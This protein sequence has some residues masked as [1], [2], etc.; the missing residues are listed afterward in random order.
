MPEA[1]LPVRKHHHHQHRYHPLEE[2]ISSPNGTV[3]TVFDYNATDLNETIEANGE[4]CNRF[5]KN[6]NITWINIDGLRQEEVQRLCKHYDVHEL[7]VEDIMSRNERPKMDEIENVIF[8]VLPMMYFNQS[9]G[10]VEMEQVSL[11]LGNDFVLSFQEEA[12][13]DVL[14]TV[15][16]HLRVENSKIRQR[17]SDYLLY[18]ILDVIVDSYFGVLEQIGDRLDTLEDTLLRRQ[19]ASLLNRISGLR[20]DVALLRRAI[21]PV[22]ELV[23][24]FVRSDSKLLEERNEKYFRDVLDHTIQATD[25]MENHR[26][27]VMNLQDL[28]MNQI[29]L[30][31][32]EVMKVFTMVATLLAPAT[33]IGGI[34]G[35]NFD[36]IPMRHQ[37]A[38]FWLAVG[39]ML[40]IP[41]LM[42]VWFKRRGWF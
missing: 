2:V 7:V 42:L 17:K 33:V 12:E 41:M 8:C 4:A 10:D 29:N 20:R 11:V 1:N 15:R 21:L 22:R 35:M 32:N 25:F 34:F 39:A 19:N 14:D 38:G 5:H 18:S 28:Y 6:G 36:V 37:G 30:K 16:R 27:M 31:M 24:H 26:E 23:A 9:T 13:R 40:I 3:Y